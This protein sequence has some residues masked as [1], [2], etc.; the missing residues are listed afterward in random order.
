MRFRFPIFR[1]RMRGALR[2]ERARCVYIPRFVSKLCSRARVR[3]RTV[4]QP[5]NLTADMTLNMYVSFRVSAPASQQ[6][7]PNGALQPVA[8]RVA[9]ET[10]QLHARARLCLFRCPLN[11]R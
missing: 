1:N 7:R 5:A 8:H 2:Q 11:G 6:R 4:A 9:V 10:H 3:A